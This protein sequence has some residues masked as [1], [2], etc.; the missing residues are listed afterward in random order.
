MVSYEYTRSLVNHDVYAPSRAAGRARRWGE[1][2][3][4]VVSRKAQAW[5]ETGGG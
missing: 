1:A 2:S 3:L 4:H 5:L